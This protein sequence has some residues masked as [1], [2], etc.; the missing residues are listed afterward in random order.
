MSHG[1]SAEISDSIV[2]KRE[3]VSNLEPCDQNDA[4][5]M[6]MVARI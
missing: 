3:I 5:G 4:A 6:E 1:A 2:L